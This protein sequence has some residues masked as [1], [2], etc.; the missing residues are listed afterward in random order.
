MIEI[1][2]GGGLI[3]L[4]AMN[5]A[6]PSAGEL[7]PGQVERFDGLMQ[8]GGGSG[9]EVRSPEAT[10]GAETSAVRGTPTLGEAILDGI[11]QMREAHQERIR[12]LDAAV[13]GEVLHLEQLLAAQAALIRLT[14]EQELIAKTV[15]KATQNLDTLLKS[16]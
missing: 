15:G 5:D 7:A 1:G 4:V 10:A 6:P 8:G 12:A 3:R 13:E 11:Q 2:G 9:G 16:Q 14:F